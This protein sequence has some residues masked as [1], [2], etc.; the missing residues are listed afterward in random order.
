MTFSENGRPGASFPVMPQD[1]RSRILDR[2]VSTH[3]SVSGAAQ[4]LQRRRPYLDRLVGEHF[5]AARDATILD[6]GCGHGAI[7]WAAQRAG[8]TNLAGVDASPEQVA[9]AARLGI[10]GVRLGDLNQALREAADGSHDLV[11]L[12]DLFHYFTREQQ[13]EIVDQVRRVLKPGGRFILHVPNSE[14]LFAA[15]M[16]DWDYLSNGSFTRASIAQLFLACDYAA[17]DCF[18]DTPAAHGLTS[19]ARAALWQVIRLGARLVL[20]AETGENGREAIFSQCLL[21]VARKSPRSGDR[22]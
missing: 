15:R 12:F 17:I 14:A 6:L 4:G 7:L 13:V 19:F 9:E 10:P 22:E 18:E 2:Y 5:P 8:Y 1:I 11:V 20:A 3:A 16:R 21:A